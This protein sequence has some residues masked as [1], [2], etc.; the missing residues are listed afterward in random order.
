MPAV[1]SNPDPQRAAKENPDE[2]A[3]LLSTHSTR[4]SITYFHPLEDREA[5]QAPLSLA[6]IR[7]IATYTRPYAARRTWLFFLTFARGL[8]LP[9]LAWMIGH[10]INGP[11]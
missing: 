8:Q 6:L 7:R 5:E 4:E 10:T 3:Q 1:P 2:A 9:L 11:I